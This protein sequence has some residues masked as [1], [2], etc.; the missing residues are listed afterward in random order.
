MKSIFST[1][2][3]PWSAC[4]KKCDIGSRTRNRHI[5]IV[6]AYSGAGCPTLS[7]GDG[8]GQVNGGCGDKCIE[9]DGTCVCTTKSGYEL[10]GNGDISTYCFL[11]ES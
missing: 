5:T 9:N 2:W 1:V 7:G 10:Q 8:C 4:N 3:S 11:V 6:P